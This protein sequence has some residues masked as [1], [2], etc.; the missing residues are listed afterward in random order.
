M[1]QSF[2]ISFWQ[3][4]L[5]LCISPF[6]P[7]TIVSS[8]SFALM[9]TSSTSATYRSS[10]RL[11]PPRYMNYSM[12]TTAPSLLTPPPQ[13]SAHWTHQQF[14]A[15]ISLQIKTQKT[16][17]IFQSAA[18]IPTPPVFNINGS[19]L[20][21]FHQFCYLGSILASTCQID[22]DIQARINHASSSFLPSSTKRSVFP[23]Y[24]MVL[25]HG[26]PTDATYANWRHLTESASSAS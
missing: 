21:V 14:Y 4:S 5:S 17:V 11:R 7:M 23:P 1:L 12:Q 9:A 13:C 3:Q 20:K 18:P 19:P 22:D 25:M 10:P 24:C 8:F 6:E 15:A 26:P 16:E 2:L